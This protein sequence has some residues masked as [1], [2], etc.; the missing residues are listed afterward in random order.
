MA[1]L[2]AS[3]AEDKG[4]PEVVGDSAYG[5]AAARAELEAEGYP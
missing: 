3:H 5:S 4:K 1:D 2:L